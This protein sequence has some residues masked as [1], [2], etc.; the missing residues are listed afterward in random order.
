MPHMISRLSGIFAAR[1]GY[2]GRSRNCLSTRAKLSSAAVLAASLLSSGLS[3]AQASAQATAAAPATANAGSQR[4]TVK[5]IAGSVLTLATDSGKTV[6]VNVGETAKILQI[7]PG[8]TDLKTATT[9]QLGEIAVGDRVLVTGRAGDADTVAASRVILMKSTDIAEKHAAEQADWQRRGSGGIVSAVDAAT[10]TLTVKN[11]ARTTQVA[12]TPKTIFRRYAG[13]SV[14]F[15]DA[16]TGTLA[17]IQPG[18]QVR[19]RGSRSEDGSG[20]QAE[21]VVS[22]SFR[23]LAGTVEAVNAGAGTVT[24]KDLATKKDVVVKVT[25]NSEVRKLPVQAAAMFAMR[26]RGGAAGAGGSGTPGAGGPGAGTS[27]PGA[28]SGSGTLRG[29]SSSGGA[30]ADASARGPRPGTDGAAGGAGGRGPGMGAG[31]PGGGGGMGGGRAGGMDLSQMVS[32]LPEGTIA[33]LKTGDAVMVVASQTA[34]SVTAITMLSGV[35][36]ILAASPSGAAPA[37]TLSPF[38]FGGGAPEGGGG[39]PQ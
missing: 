20:L 12:T 24:L 11:G 3:I 39:G 6:T 17:Q 10:G 32:R 37:I 31:G 8:S 7:A 21:E 27:T 16:Q 34:G 2:L 36:P 28:G 19:V 30:G 26:A 29:E 14:K 33:D 35:E 13:D 9:I 38:G 1:S 15:E 4:G 18:D 5:A 22:G 23:N 25:A